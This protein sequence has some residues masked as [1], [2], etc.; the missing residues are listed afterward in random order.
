MANEKAIPV[1][2]FAGLQEFS[3]S[4]SVESWAFPKSAYQKRRELRVCVRTREVHV[5]K[6]A[7]SGF[8]IESKKFAYEKGD[9]PE[10]AY[11]PKKFLYEKQAHPC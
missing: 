9:R 7:H 3:K 4:F 10:F 8:A 1:F 11:E 6:G 2:S 5:Q